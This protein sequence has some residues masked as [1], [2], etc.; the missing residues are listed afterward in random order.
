MVDQSGKHKR[1]QI[2]SAAIQD[3][4][5][6]EALKT[7]MVFQHDE[8]K[9]RAAEL[10][11]ANKELAFQNEEKEKRAAEL[12]I[13]N[14]ELAFQNEEKEKRAAEL[15]IANK[16]LAF[17]N[18]EKEKR[19]TELIIANKELA[20]QNGEKEKRAAELLIANKELAFQNEEKEK[21]A[22]ELIIANKELA[23]QNEEKEKRA[24]E[25]IIA[26]KELLFQ[27]EE[28]E[29][30]ANELAIA[31]LELEKAQENIRKLNQDDIRLLN[32]ALEKK[33]SDRTEELKSVNSEL[34][35]FS[36][37]VSHDLRAPLRIV[38]GYASILHDEYNQLFDDEG[39]RLLSIIQESAKKMGF[40]IDDLLAF[41]R[42]GRKEI[43]KSNIDMNQLVAGVI[44]ELSKLAPYKTT[45]TVDHL[46]SILADKALIIQVWM[47]LLSN[48]IKY[49][50]HNEHAAVHIS[51]EQDNG[52]IIYKVQ[53]NGVG[54]DMRY[55]HK[56]FGVFQ[57]LHDAEEFEGVGV[58]L[59]LVHRIIKK[60]GG[61]IWATAVLNEG[62]IFYFSL[63]TSS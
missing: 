39:K 36:Y 46:G 51:C 61:K 12:L 49:S 59:A 33:V 54:F 21:R 41:S 26:N 62:A 20:F 56:L 34:E 19:A 55:A 11:I 29:K 35:S 31:N 18:Q 13:A 17:Q 15:L 6:T 28:K 47:N 44:T 8:K 37:S 53:D 52:V 10:L 32:E 16:E 25:L 3:S 58:G 9:K 23:F 42:L 24:V 50:M 22:T 7:E 43:Y 27:N 57:R 4:T 45:I 30:R 38:N 63:P 2:I 14:K 5:A 1:L 60:H 48:A 40:L